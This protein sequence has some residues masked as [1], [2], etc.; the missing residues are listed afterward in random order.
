M[1]YRLIALD[2][3]GTLKASG[4]GISERVAAAVGRAL[5]AGAVVTIATGRMFRST[6]PFALELGLS[7]PIIC[8]QGALVGDPLSGR[9]LWHRTMPLDLARRVIVEARAAGMHLNVFVGEE[10][11]V[12]DLSEVA[13]RY[14]TVAG[15]PVHPVGDML[16]FLDREPI[17]IVVRGDEAQT[18]DFV[19]HVRSVFGETLSVCKSFPTFCEI[20][21][22]DALKSKALAWLAARLG[23]ARQDTLAIGDSPN[24]IDM[25]EW[26]GLG[27]A[28]A[29]SAPEV[30]AAAD[31]LAPGGPGD[32][33][34]GLIEEMLSLGL[35]GR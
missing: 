2:L 4:E 22:P 1:P 17:K 27:V 18:E 32:G 25:L 12:E 16:E 15:I 20:G 30:V 23:V 26:A 24:D 6:R 14:S 19:G 29:G 9:V 31:R 8:Y 3:D 34:A 13:E 7:A 28:I 11:Y 21:H 10:Y 5:A 35:L 33:V